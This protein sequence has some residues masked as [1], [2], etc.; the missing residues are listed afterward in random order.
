LNN[1]GIN[2]ILITYF[3]KKWVKETI[4]EIVEEVFTF[5]VFK[6]MMVGIIGVIISLSFLAWGFIAV[7]R[8]YDFK[9][10]CA[11][12]L[13]LAG[14]APTVEK[15]DEF[16]GHAPQYMERRGHTNGSA[17]LILPFPSTNVGIWYEEI[18]GAKEATA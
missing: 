13:E 5:Y 7:V 8:W 4:K 11:D 15:A 18:K 10:N 16:L 14:D 6:K 2:R 12:Y 9:S 1:G 17:A 3:F